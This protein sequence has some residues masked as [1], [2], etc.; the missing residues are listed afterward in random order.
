MS[1]CVML[2]NLARAEAYIRSFIPELVYP[3]QQVANVGGDEILITI[4]IV[5][6]VCFFDLMFDDCC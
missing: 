2:H 3:G 5:V 6:I 1:L 4:F